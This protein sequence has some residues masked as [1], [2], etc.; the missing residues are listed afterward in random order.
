MNYGYNR[1]DWVGWGEDN[2]GACKDRSTVKATKQCAEMLIYSKVSNKMKSGNKCI[3]C[4]SQEGLC[5]AHIVPRGLGTFR[6][7][8]TLE[9]KVCRSCDTE[10]GKAEEQLIKCGP[11]A[12][13]REVLGIK[14]RSGEKATS[15]FRRK[16]AGQ[17]PLKLKMKYPGTNYDILVELIPGSHNFQALPQIVVIGQDGKCEHVLVNDKTLTSERLHDE[18]RATGLKGHVMLWPLG[19]EGEEEKWI[20]RITE[21]L[22]IIE[23]SIDLN[24]KP[25]NGKASGNCELQVDARYFRAIAKIGFHY[26]L[27]YTER[28]TGEEDAFLPLKNFIRYGKG[29]LEEFVRTSRKT[30]IR[31]IEKGYVPKYYGHFVIGEA[32]PNKICAHLQ[33]FFGHD[34]NPL[35]YEVH[36]GENPMTILLTPETF[37]HFYNYFK[38]DDRQG[39]D[40]EI[41]ALGTAVRIILPQ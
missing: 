34:V 30:K 18:I 1:I 41:Q 35:W 8:P 33:L 37:G 9:N 32:E 20:D 19:F 24:F 16:H 25:Y 36:L 28:F 15:P 14:G 3:Y 7:Q 10:I 22:K 23:G 11:E 4:G 12:F 5:R 38:P 40:G 17:G 27:A 13:H 29:R 21:G 2:E 6:D 26:F 39:F 31:E